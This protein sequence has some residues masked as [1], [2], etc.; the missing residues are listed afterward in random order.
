MAHGFTL[1]FGGTAV[2][3]NEVVVTTPAAGSD[4]SATGGFALHISGLKGGIDTES[5]TFRFLAGA[6]TLAPPVADALGLSDEQSSGVVGRL[7]MRGLATWIAGDRPIG[8]LSYARRESESQPGSTELH[9]V[10]SG[11]GASG[12]DMTF[13]QL[14]GLSQYARTA[15][16][17]GMALATTSWNIGTAPS[18][19]Y[20]NP[21]VRHPF[22]VSNVFRLEDGRFEQIGQSWV[23][24]GFCAVDNEQ[25]S[26]SCHGTGCT[27]LGVGCTDTYSA[28]L[29]ATQSLLGPRSEINPWSGAFVFEGSHLDSSHS[30]SA[31]DHLLL[32]HDSDLNPGDHENAIFFAESYYVVPDDVD[33][34]NN[35]AHKPVTFSGPVNGEWDIGM[36]GA[37]AAPLVGPALT[38]WDGASFTLL[39]QELPVVEFE[40]PD[41]RCLLGATATPI[42]DTTWH[43][44]YALYNIDMDRKVGGFRI[45]VPDNATITNAGFHY[46]FVFGDVYGNTD[47]EWGRDEN[48]VYWHT[49]D[50]PCRWG[51]LYNFRFDADVPPADTTVTLTHFEPGLPET[52]TGT[53]LGPRLVSWPAPRFEPPLKN[54]YLSFFAGVREEEAE[55]VQALR[56]RCREHSEHTWW[57]DV[58]DAN[59]V[60]R[61]S[62]EPV[63]RDWGRKRLHIGDLPV[64]AGLTYEIQGLPEGGDHSRESEFSE[65]AILTT[66]AVNGD[67][68]GGY[69]K[70]Y[71]WLPPDGLATFLDI[72]AVWRGYAGEPSA[73]D[74]LRIDIGAGVPDGLIDMRDVEA[75]VRA[76]EYPGQLSGN[77]PACE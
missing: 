22:I 62:C 40:S 57:V 19:W 41:G 44:E 31:I 16:F 29:N 68:T 39:A 38:S 67:V 3:I 20:A 59:G 77:L 76:F 12:P 49:N 56:L 45:P 71:G 63:F 26:T 27:S 17:V 43:Y 50:N 65:L 53:T 60:C 52:V 70:G 32:M 28:D 69:R 8:Q 73:P 15:G 64:K 4:A 58:P 37:S 33:V 34:S 55:T 30:H 9:T 35:F 66:T 51:T 11:A 72:Q 25:C 18:E 6:V 74:V 10:A 47:W 7:E 48:G 14:F 13:C 54:R 42:D 36:S 1:T 23:K 75:A 21:D 46:P 2:T 61:L 24:H 5:G